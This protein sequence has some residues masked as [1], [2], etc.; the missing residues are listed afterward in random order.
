[1]ASGVK[2]DIS[3]DAKAKGSLEKSLKAS[4]TSVDDPYGVYSL[5]SCQRSRHALSL[6]VGTGLM[7]HGAHGAQ[8]SWRTGL[9]TH[10]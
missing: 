9:M 1:M 10:A 6:A 2:S 8:G 5:N 3:H 7:A 4:K